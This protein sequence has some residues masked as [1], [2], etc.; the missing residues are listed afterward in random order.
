MLIQRLVCL[1]F[2]HQQLR[3]K[4]IIFHFVIIPNKHL[5]QTQIPPKLELYPVNFEF[6][7]SAWQFLINLTVHSLNYACV[8][9]KETRVSVWKA[10]SCR[11]VK[12]E[13][14]K[15]R[16]MSQHPQ[17]VS[18]FWA[19]VVWKL[20]AA[21]R[22]PVNSF[23]HRNPRACKTGSGCPLSLAMLFHPFLSL[24]ITNSSLFS[25]PLSEAESVFNSISS[26]QT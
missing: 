7:F 24:Y 21:L 15:E 13:M 18:V 22:R 1:N 2:C 11:Q 14:E 6:S 26:H 4:W 12:R 3:K 16:D 20:E 17:D 19:A 9:E 5:S 23:S 8:I 25:V 10:V